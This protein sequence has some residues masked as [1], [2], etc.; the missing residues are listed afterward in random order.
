VSRRHGGPYTEA[1]AIAK[2]PVSSAGIDTVLCD[3]GDVI[4]MFDRAVA[5]DIETRHGLARDTLL[6]RP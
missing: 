3:V 4:L 5:A 2:M 1:E 6:L